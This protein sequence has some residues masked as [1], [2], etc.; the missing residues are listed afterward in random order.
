M[1]V[2][3]KLLRGGGEAGAGIAGAAKRVMEEERRESRERGDGD[4]F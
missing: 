4:G 2:H 3:R 1:R